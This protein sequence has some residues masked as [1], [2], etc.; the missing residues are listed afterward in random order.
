MKKKFQRA[1]F[2]AQTAATVL[3]ALGA[4]APLFA[5]MEGEV[6]VTGQA[7]RK[8]N[9]A[10]KFEEY[11]TVPEGVY[12]E[13]LSVQTE[14][15]KS[16]CYID[17]KGRKLGLDDQDFALKTGKWGLM[18]MGV[19]YDQTPHVYANNARSFFVNNGN[20]NFG[21]SDQLQTDL[22]TST[23]NAPA[24]FTNVPFVP[25][26]IRRDTVSAYLKLSPM[27][28][29]RIGLSGKQE[30]R[31][32]TKV[33]GA[34]TPFTEI[35]EPIKYHTQ[36]VSVSAEVNQELFSAVLSYNGSIFKNDID[37]L[38]YDN[39]WRLTPAAI[40]ASGS[41][42][43]DKVRLGLPPDNQSHNFTLA[44]GANL[45]FWQSRLN[46]SLSYGWTSQNDAFLPVTANQNIINEANR[47]GVAIDPSRPS[48]E[49]KIK[50]LSANSS[51]IL[52]PI[53]PLTL[54]GKVRYYKMDNQTPEL[55]INRVRLDQLF[56]T[57]TPVG[58][59][60]PVYTRKS[61]P[62]SY[63]KLNLGTDLSYQVL[64]DLSLGLGYEY[65][66]MK[67]D[68][69]DVDV[70]K[71]HTLKASLNYVPRQWIALRPNYLH[72]N[73]YYDVYDHEKVEHAIYPIG[74]GTN[75]IGTHLQRFDQT[76]RLRDVAGIKTSIFPLDSL[77]LDAE[78]VYRL[79]D[80]M[81]TEYG[82]QKEKNH[83]VSMD[84]TYEPSEILTLF[85]NYSVEKTVTDM[86][87]RYRESGSITKLP[88]DLAANDWVSTAEDLTDGFGLG[89]NAVLIKKKLDLDAS[90]A[91]TRSRGQLRA[92]NPNT[93]VTD[94]T[95]GTNTA[96]T[97][98]ANA[99]AR[100]YP[101]TENE[102]HKWLASLKWFL[103]ENLTLR[104]N[105]SYERYL[106]KDYAIDGLSVWQPIVTD[107]NNYVLNSN[108]YVFLGWSPENYDAH[109]VGL[110][111]TY[112]F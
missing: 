9:N 18:E 15:E 64:S 66:R 31:N 35:T 44:G 22:Q 12:L 26:R 97:Q 49:G 72:A 43:P 5:A 80:Y 52:K 1:S 63:S 42:A 90:F 96:A 95:K 82:T 59:F 37:A 79:D 85:G 108:Q 36:D 24:V 34:Y 38:T 55:Q 105:Y 28:N 30:D 87:L 53:N 57:A 14:H 32:G 56:S 48:L 88:L 102:T 16:N 33:T 60:N 23:N 46:A 65:E 51:L 62:I 50:T 58:N 89:A 110:S 67:R 86:H 70:T 111:L 109:T 98:G 6:T 10:A 69:R 93:I 61:V 21:L 47:L 27:D 2:A 77:T 94:G 3:L 107:V 103:V 68:N 7:V 106:A 73:R 78:Y 45:P 39:P 100:D 112:K 75:I 81:G 83:A 104:L 99:V 101:E 54:T 11:R 17:I 20:G 92:S 84:V 8:D 40:S 25:L 13:K 76:S 4:A 41:S 74:E 91:F 19:K 29:L 71:E